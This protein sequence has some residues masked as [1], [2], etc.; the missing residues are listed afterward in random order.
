MA[1]IKLFVFI[2]MCTVGSA[3]AWSLSALN[4]RDPSANIEICF[5]LDT[6][7][8]MSGLIEG[9]KDTIWSIANNIVSLQPLPNVKFCLIA[10]RDRGDKYVTRVSDLN[11]DI[12]SIYSELKR[13]KAQ[14]G[15]D[16]PESVNQALGEAIQSI[17]WSQ[18]P[19]DIRIIY[20]VGDAPPHMDYEERQYPDLSLDA[21]E[22]DIVINTLQCGS[23]SATTPVWQ[24]IARATQGFYSKLQQSGNVK[25]V[26]TPMD[27]DFYALNKKIGETLL[28]YGSSQ[29]RKAIVE[30]QQK[31]QNEKQSVVADRLS[32]NA[33]TQR[34]KQGR[35]DLLDDIDAGLVN[36]QALD[37]SQLPPDLRGLSVA[38]KNTVLAKMR[39]KRSVYQDT[40]NALD[41]ERRN[42]IR[43]KTNASSAS[44]DREVLKGIQD[45]AKRKGLD[46]R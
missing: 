39:H 28:P 32:Y 11:S 38:D 13:Y 4:D 25:V 8:S 42:F 40:I 16:T 19:K 2:L 24:H 5:V 37:D 34:L 12:D 35:G 9:A 44:F 46:L 20:L 14:G 23:M 6:T 22:K 29:D 45:L 10:F 3:P 18:N 27:Q 31:T 21:K 43:E 36:L 33:K 41:I 30:Q 17:S 15:G 7:G 1:S 26:T